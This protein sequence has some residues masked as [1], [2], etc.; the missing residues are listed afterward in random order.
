MAP[1]PLIGTHWHGYACHIPECSS[2]N[3]P[4]TMQVACA[5]SL[6]G[7]WRAP[8]FLVAARRW[9]RRAPHGALRTSPSARSARTRGKEAQG[10]TPCSRPLSTTPLLNADVAPVDGAASAF[11]FPHSFREGV[12]PLCRSQFT[13]MYVVLLSLETG[14]AVAAP[15]AVRAVHQRGCVHLCLPRAARL[16]RFAPADR[17]VTV[18]ITKSKELHTCSTTHSGLRPGCRGHITSTNGCST[19]LPMSAGNVRGAISG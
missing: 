2:N 15:S 1:S 4:P 12:E 19:S 5:S 9:S 11:L 16:C 6:R 10:A 8:P 3:A 18:T 13:R 14:P 7:F 17:I